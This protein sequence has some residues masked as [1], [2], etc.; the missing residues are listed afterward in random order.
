MSAANE[1]RRRLSLETE[2][3]RGVEEEEN[4]KEDSGQRT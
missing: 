3:G 4:E 2:D 1:C